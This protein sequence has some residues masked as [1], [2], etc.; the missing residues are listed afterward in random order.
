MIIRVIQGKGKKDRQVK[1]P[2]GLLGLPRAWWPLRS[3]RHDAG[4]SLSERWLFPGGKADEPTLPRQ[5]SRL[6]CEVERMAE[7]TRR[8]TLHSLRHSFATTSWS[9]VPIFASF[10]RCSGTAS[11]T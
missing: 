7:I 11:W 6:F 9:V 2:K 8:V 3:K 5:F 1:L 4:R 10:W